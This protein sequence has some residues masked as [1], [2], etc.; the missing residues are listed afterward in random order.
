M[1]DL[2]VAWGVYPLLFAVLAVGCGLILEAASGRRL[3][4]ALLT[5]AGVAVIVV[6]GQFTTLWDA[7]AELTVPLVV[8]LA[9]AGVGVSGGIRGRSLEGPLL[10][11]ALATFAFFAAPVVLSG[12][13]TFAGY[14][15]LDDTATWFAL[16]DHVME[17]G[18]DLGGL[19]P[20]SHEA[21]VQ[22]NLDAGYP[23]GAFVPLGVGPVLTGTDV[24]WLFQPHLALLAGFLCL[25]L[26]ELAR[27][28]VA[29]PRALAAVAFIASI[30]A[31]LVGY[32]L[33]GGIKELEAALLVALAAALA[34]DAAGSDRGARALLPLGVAAAAL[35]AVLG[36]GGAAWLVCLL[37]P[38]AVLAA[39]RLGVKATARALGWLTAFVA[40]LSLPLV[41]VGDFFSPTQEGL[42]SDSEI[43][44]LVEPLEPLQLAGIW[45]AGDFRLDP[46]A[47]VPAALLIVLV[48][49]A[50]AA[51]LALGLYRRA[52]PLVVYGTGALAGVALICAVASPWV[53]GKAMATVSPVLLLLAGSAVAVLGAGGRRAAAA[54]LAALIGAGVLWS[55]GLAYRDVSLAPRDQL[56]EL[57]RIGEEFAGEGPVLMTEYQPYGVRHFLRDADPE[58]ASELR[59][60]LV[61]LAA[62]G[63]LAKGAYADTDR[64]AIDSL[65]MYRTLVLRR[66]PGQSRPPF[67][68]MPAASGDHYEV[69]QRPAGAGEAVAEHLGLGGDVVASAVPPCAAVRAMAARA[70]PGQS[71][72]A[73]TREPVVAVP[74]SEAEYTRAWVTADPDYP[75]HDGAGLIRAEVTVPAAGEYTLW[76]G[77]SVRPRAE[78]RVDGE[79]AGEVRHVLNNAGQYVRL[80][81]ARLAAGRHRVEVE[82]GP[83]D[84]APGSGG[85]SGALGP[86]VL[87]PSESDPE[88]HVVPPGRAAELCGREWDW[89]ELGTPP[90]A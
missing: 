35:P 83:T 8:V 28:V 50:A 56:A 44:N 10:A 46:V 12:E 58:G 49:G 47:P 40:L 62:G 77:G 63:S 13:A 66:S 11:A 72:V 30:P 29:D 73:A 2:I 7:T 25:A 87:S 51:G 37:A 57:E 21:T 27:G 52:A 68:Y 90:G 86:L 54:A 38:A 39:H 55:Y 78:T 34:G 76:L 80:G 20:S 75:A 22:I 59:R 24:A 45:P 48:A 4:P 32:A 42:T 18:R 31:L 23:A 36:L 5:G 79:E 64:L 1:L 61:P 60:R 84:L 14:I 88:L 65:M 26:A 43:G 41:F 67:P 33:W 89:I 53:D 82:I 9:A 3:A 15:R 71:L 70:A 74:L 17:H 6:V 16:T 69:W 19:A 85:G 81:A